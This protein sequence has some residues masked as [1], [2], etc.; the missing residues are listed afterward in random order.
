MSK[1]TFSFLAVILFFFFCGSPLVGAYTVTNYWTSKEG[2]GEPTTNFTTNTDTV[3]INVEGSHIPS[4]ITSS[5]MSMRWYKPDGEREYDLGTN[6]ISEHV[7]SNAGLLIGFWAEM[8]I[9]GMNREPGQWMVKHYVY[10]WQDDVL[11]WHNLFT[12]SFTISDIQLGDINGIDGVDLVDAVLALQVLS[13]LEPSSYVYIEADVNEDG[14]IGL[15]EVIYGLQVISEKRSFGIQSSAFAHSDPI[16]SKYTCSGTDVS[17][18]LSWQFA[19]AGTKSFVVIMDDPDA[20]G[21]TWDHWIVY[22][23]PA[24]IT[25]LSEN[26][27]ASGGGSLPSQAIHGTNSW[28]NT[29]YQGPC[30]PSDTHRYFFKLYS[31]SV[32][33]LNPSATSKAEIEA[34]MA[35]NILGQTEL[36]GTCTYTP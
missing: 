28:N 32:S 17:P 8:V 24:S 31:L 11:D 36:M 14:K 19:P 13:G 16:P 21:G 9:K 10:G 23:I 34:A 22:N 30:P 33:Q 3:Y 20:P 2:W 29:Y 18:P 35:G 5:W 27:G 6:L 26:A 7:Y 12:Q 1:K 25:S 15:E 4:P